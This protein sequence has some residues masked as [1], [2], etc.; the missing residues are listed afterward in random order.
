MIEP[1]NVMYVVVNQRTRKTAGMT[2]SKRNARLIKK[3]AEKGNDDEW[4]IEIIDTS[5]AA[6][7]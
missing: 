4:T 1:Q 5:E 7:S 3:N 2:N 6:P